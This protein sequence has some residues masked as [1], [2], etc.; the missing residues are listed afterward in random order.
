MRGAAVG[1]S[2]AAA[3]AGVL[4]GLFPSARAARLD[5]A[6]VLRGRW[7][8]GPRSRGLPRG[9]VVGTICAGCRLVPSGGLR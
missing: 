4:A 9:R 8:A 6:D 3:V 7:V 1:G 2:V 5:P